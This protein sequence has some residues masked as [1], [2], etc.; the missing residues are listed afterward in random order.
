ML[1]PEFKDNIVFVGRDSLFVEGLS[2]AI[3]QLEYIVEVPGCDSAVSVLQNEEVQ[4]RLIKGS[5]ILTFKPASKLEFLAKKHGWNLV[6]PLAELNRRIENKISVM[7]VFSKTELSMLSCEVIEPNK[8]SWDELS[9]KLGEVIVAQTERGHAGSSSFILRSEKDF[10]NLESGQMTKFS[11]FLKGE[12]WTVNACATRYGTLSSRPFFQLQGETICGIKD[13]LGT[14]G[15]QHRSID[16]ALAE[17]IM[18]DTKRF[19]DHLY[20]EGY[21]GWFG[22]DV[23]IVD[24]K[25]AGYIECNPRLTAS[26]GIFTEMQVEANQ[27]PFILLHILEILDRDYD[28]DLVSEQVALHKG[29][30][31]SH[32]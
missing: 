28:L 6:T 16:D 26:V 5:N 13:E 10:K 1:Q 30:S 14:C 15:N 22:L 32:L 19:G 27:T 31:E 11:R 18:D 4:K 29:F 21:R 2:S 17:Q 20:S 3:P 24:G 12:T 8:I 7:E 23:L 25:I 9:E